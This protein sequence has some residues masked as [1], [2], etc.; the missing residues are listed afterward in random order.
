METAT[1]TA[2][3]ANATWFYEMALDE[4]AA[5]GK[6]LLKRPDGAIVE[7]PLRAG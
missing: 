6:V 7:M 2:V 4:T 1:F 3:V 5:G